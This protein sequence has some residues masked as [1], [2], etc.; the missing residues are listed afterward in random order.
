MEI[1]AQNKSTWYHK[2]LMSGVAIV[3]FVKSFF[4]WDNLTKRIK[5]YKDIPCTDVWVMIDTFQEFVFNIMVY[6]A[7]LWIIFV[8]VDI[9]NMI[10]NSIAM[11]FLMQLD[12]DFQ[13]YYFKFLPGAAEDIYDEVF[14]SPHENRQIIKEKLEESRSF[15]AL[16]TITYF[17]FKLL[18]SSL[19]FF[20]IIYLF[21]IFFGPICK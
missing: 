21:M 19:L 6:G 15:R 7:N 20:P 14:V 18:I 1:Y 8:E 12:N 9:Q 2:L 16:S 3:Y 13:T 11:E 10:L 4:I 5:L 17:P